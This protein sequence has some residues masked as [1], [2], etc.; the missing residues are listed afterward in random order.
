MVNYYMQDTVNFGLLPKVY[1]NSGE[2]VIERT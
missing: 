2:V 1:N